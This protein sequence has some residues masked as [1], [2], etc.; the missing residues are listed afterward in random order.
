MGHALLNEDD[1][2]AKHQALLAQVD[3]LRSVDWQRGPHWEGI[4]GKLTPKGAVTVAGSKETAHAIFAAL[5]EEGT[6]AFQK[7]RRI[8]E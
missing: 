5:N 4:A 1:P 6:A 8:S 7:V 3:K 2:Q